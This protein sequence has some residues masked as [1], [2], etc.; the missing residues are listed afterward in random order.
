MCF[1]L[2]IPLETGK[3]S[4]KLKQKTEPESLPKIKAETELEILLNVKQ[5]MELKLKKCS[6]N[7]YKNYNI[8]CHNVKDYEA[9]VLQ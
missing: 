3:S 8:Q 7:V 4:G 5:Q 9:H 1:V 2:N 6:K